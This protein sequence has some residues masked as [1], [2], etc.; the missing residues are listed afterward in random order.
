MANFLVEFDAVPLGLVYPVP[1]TID[2]TFRPDEYCFTNLSSD[3]D[4]FFS[5][6]GVNDH[7]VLRP[8]TPLSSQTYESVE[9]KVWFRTGP[10]GASLAAPMVVEAATD[11]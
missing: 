8:A 7:G 6:D 9:R 5:F 1:P 2:L 4:A 10:V 3:T 11:T